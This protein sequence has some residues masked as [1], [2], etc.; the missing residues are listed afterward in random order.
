M[1]IR[2][3][4]L[5]IL[6]SAWIGN[7]ASEPL[8][9]TLRVRDFG[10]VPD[11]RR[12][13]SEALRGAIAAIGEKG[14]PAVLY[15][16]PGRY[17]FYAPEGMD[18]RATVVAELRGIRN[19]TIDGGGAELIAHGR[20]TLFLA[21]ACEGLT[22]RNF[23]LDWER[24]YIT[25]G[26]IV[27]LGDGHVDL[28][29]DRT[30][31]PYRF[32]QDRIRFT[33]E[34]W[35]RGVDPESYS[36]AYDPRSG[37]VLY[38]TRDYPLSNRNTLF[39]GKA[40]EVAP[41]TVRFFGTVDRQ[42]PVGTE[43]ALYHG[44][45]LSNAMT[46][47]KCR[48]LR[49][50]KIDLRHSPGMGIYG[51]RCENILLKE[52]RTVVDRA[53]N[54][55]FSCVADALHFTNCR[56]SIELDGCDFD[57]QGDDALN[58]HGTYVRVA[59]IS[60]ERRQIELLGDRFPAERV[61][62]SG[63]AVW[64]I[65]RGTVSRGDVNRIERIVGMN[66][67]R[68]VVELQHPLDEAF[69]KDDFIENAA[70]CPDVWIHDCRFGRANRARGILLTSPGRVVVSGNRFATAGTAI[71][72]EGDIDYWFE[73]GA[74]RDLEICDNLFE[75]CGTSASNNGGAGWGEAV[76][77]ITP[78]FR[79]ADANSPAYHRNIRIR[80][81]RI[82]T[83]DRPLLHA[84]SVGGL[85]FVANRIEQTSDFPATAA[86]RES[87]RLDGCRDVRI[88]ENRFIGYGEPDFRL[89]HMKHD[90]LRHEETK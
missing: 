46:V 70:W 8:A 76:I 26:T 11:S 18:D 10:A 68:L 29:I 54:R 24:P 19:L 6:A 20:L 30:R 15:F 4:L 50:E 32:E 47:V 82:L 39:R 73:S 77:S 88:A 55:R 81:N 64:P 78:S 13:A 58:I 34:T 17:D 80:N 22:L 3:Y 87:F 7:A 35:E 14:T 37:A 31:Y 28:A 69:Q 49:F 79:P 44:R 67:E 23:T 65:H 27:A 63:D 52:V 41:D 71:L 72:I 33:G 36:T 66:G 51:L 83:Y 2:R 90:D 89:M 75:N 60:K 9:D 5:L 38:G 56:G 12:D 57:G 40:R 85:Q 74:V 48:D 86:Q 61:F 25:Q 59:A 45:Y 43:L 16:G 53:Q 42:L 1:A 62:E 84:R 21:E